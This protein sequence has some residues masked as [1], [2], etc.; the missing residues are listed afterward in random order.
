MS[1]ERPDTSED[2]SKAGSQSGPTNGS[3]SESPEREPETREPETGATGR[4]REGALE[5]GDIDTVV[6]R[7]SWADRLLGAAVVILLSAI[8]VTLLLQVIMRYFFGA[9]LPWSAELSRY[10][11]VWLTFLG[12]A[13]AYR[14]SAH[15]G[16]DVLAE[17]LSRRFSAVP[18]HVLNGAIRGIVMLFLIAFLVGGVS[19]VQ[20]TTGQVTPGLQIS[21]AWVY[22]A[23]PVSSLIMILSAIGEAVSALYR[24]I[25][26]AREASR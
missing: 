25:S 23:I 18:A 24:R 2:N 17:Y 1:H 3:F 5:A 21:M 19:L 8:C 20:Q 9:P 22:L 7:D 6:L 14:L 15:I 10:L 4:S 11:F 16:V 12:A 13:L 26:D